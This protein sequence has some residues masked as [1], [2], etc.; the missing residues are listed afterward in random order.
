[1]VAEVAWADDENGSD[2]DLKRLLEPTVVI[3]PTLYDGFTADR[4][5]SSGGATLN[6]TKNTCDLRSG[7]GVLGSRV[8]GLRFSAT[9]C[10]LDGNIGVNGD[11]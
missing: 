1:M 6:A 9:C 11:I 10:G 4:N 3:S 2:A 5:K 7:L 8:H